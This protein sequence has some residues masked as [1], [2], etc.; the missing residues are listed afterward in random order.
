[1]S[2][3]RNKLINLFIGNISNSV[4]H[5]IL[6]KAIDEEDI[7]KRYGK[8]FSIS[9]DIA[10]KYREKINPINAPLPDKDIRYIKDKIIQKVRVELEKRI[11]KRYKN[12]DL[13]L[14]EPTVNSLL[15][16]MNATQ[17]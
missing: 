4:T 12:I 7:R 3:N 16:R 9:L 15:K 14:I 10:K 6:E 5:K 8:E 1:M 17:N 11:S 2:Q 13:E